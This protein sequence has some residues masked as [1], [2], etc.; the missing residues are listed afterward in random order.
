MQRRRREATYREHADG[1]DGL[2]VK[3]AVTHFC[4]MYLELVL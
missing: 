2:L 1:V 4:R 3:L